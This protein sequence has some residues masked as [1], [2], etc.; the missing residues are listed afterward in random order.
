M[1]VKS[2]VDELAIHGGAP[3]FDEP[4]HVGRP[5]I[6]DRRALFARLDAALDRRWLTN[7]GPLVEELEG[8]IAQL[9]GID[10]VIAL[11]NATVGLEVLARASGLKGEVIVP[12]FTFVATAHALQWLGIRPIF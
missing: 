8:R 10:H 12:S 5:N 7:E 3:T 9:V 6:G 2:S 11:C 1:R 4:L